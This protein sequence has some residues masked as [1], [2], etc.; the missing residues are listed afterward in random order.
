MVDRAA[1]DVGFYYA[2]N[3][4]GRFIGTLA[5]GLL[6]AAAGLPACLAAAAA[7]LALAVLIAAWLPTRSGKTVDRISEAPSD[8][9]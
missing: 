5:S 2:A 9:L 6:F 8:S 3:A 1:E 7:M 4:V